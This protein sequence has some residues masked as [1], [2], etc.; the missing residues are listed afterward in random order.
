MCFNANIIVSQ[1]G[2]HARV[3]AAPRGRA[4]LP[5]GAR[6]RL[7]WEA[8]RFPDAFR[9]RSTSSTRSGWRASMWPRSSPTRRTSR[10]RLPDAGRGGAAAGVDPRRTRVARRP[11]PCSCWRSTLQHRGAQEPARPDRRVHAGV[12]AGRR[13]A[14]RDQDDQR[15][16]QAAELRR[17]RQAPVAVPTSASSTTTS[18]AR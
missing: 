17:L 15:R 13:P 6:W 9:P 4:L 7:V 3:H 8:S 2:A 11:L 5:H 1:P 10:A 12:R 16:Q 18:P 14:P